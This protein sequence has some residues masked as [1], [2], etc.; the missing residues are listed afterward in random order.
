MVRF[1][2]RSGSH[3]T[4]IAVYNKQADNQCKIE[5]SLAPLL[6]SFLQISR[7]AQ[8]TR[9]SSG[10]PAGT[11]KAPKTYIRYLNR[12][13]LKLLK[14]TRA[15]PGRSKTSR[16]YTDTCPLHKRRAG[17]RFLIRTPSGCLVEY[18]HLVRCCV[19][20]FFFVS[21]SAFSI[22]QI[23]RA[24]TIVDINSVHNR[25]RERGEMGNGK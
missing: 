21:P 2:C 7:P 11:A 23:A 1:E 15:W 18:E 8:C 12:L 25:G 16:S 6:W 19:F 9:T 10:H 17:F 20:T 13:W 3:P 14:V 5:Q 24:I 22:L 4:G